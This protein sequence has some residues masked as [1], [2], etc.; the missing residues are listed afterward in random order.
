MEQTKKMLEVV[1]QAVKEFHIDQTA[2][3][4][5][6]ALSISD[7]HFTFD[8]DGQWE[9]LAKR[10]RRGKPR[11]TINQVAAAV[12][13][14][15]G[16]YRQNQI[17][18]KALPEQDQ[19]KAEADTYN[20][21]IRGILAGQNAEA[22]KDTAFKGITVGG[23]AAA[24]VLNQYTDANPFEQDVEIE[25]I[26]DAPE[27]VWFDAKAK[28]MTGK[29]GSHVFQIASITRASFSERW[30]WA[31]MATWSN[32]QITTY[33][34]KWGLGG[35]SSDIRIAD[36]YVK[37]P[38][39][40]NKSLLSDGT[41]MI[42]EEYLEVADELAAKEITLV[43]AKEVDTFKVMH[44]KMSGSEILEKPVELPTSRL[45]IIRC[46]G[47][48]E[49]RD[50]ALHYRGIVR[51]AKDPQRVY[52]YATSANI[53]AYAL[54][55]KQKVLATKKQI[56]GHEKTWRTLNTS[57][58]SVLTYTV[59]PDV[60]GGAPTPFHAVGGSPELVQ[61]AQQ[62]Q[63]D[64]QATIGRRAPA[65]GESAGDRSGPAILA[66]QRQ[67]D[68]V[69]FE[70]LDNLAIFWQQVAEVTMDM[71]P[72]VY[73]TER[74]VM[75]LG[76]DGETEVVTLNL[77]EKDEQ[78]GKE[79]RKHDT[80]RRYRIKST[81]GPAFETKRSE[82]VNVLTTL[83]QDPEMKPLVGDLFAK[84]LDFPMADELTSRIRKQQLK[85]GVV[86][87]NE[88]EQAAAQAAAQ[89]PEAQQQA[90]L[91]QQIQQMQLQSQVLQLQRM[92]LENANLE[93]NIANLQAAT[94]EKAGSAAKD[95]ADIQE[96]QVNVYAKQVDT[97]ISQIEAGLAVSPSQLETVQQSMQLL[98]ATQRDE[99]NRRIQEQLNKAQ[100][101]QPQV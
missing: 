67:D 26:Y 30:P 52:N 5:Q 32:S 60:P 14:T 89:T 40:V 9:D 84:N 15:I 13:E 17:E 59:D 90:Q 41:I 96:T 35:T 34:S 12:N 45:P 48:H 79:F 73:D 101:L 95:V 70:L 19:S 63:L 46:L 47:Y 42:T 87:P 65:Q 7:G 88:E 21:L 37:E 31:S 57:D 18:M 93:A 24:R 68:A 6:R 85:L 86:E 92:Q 56:A 4:A 44:Y 55:P 33:Q 100:Q 2:D 83:M 49:W 62:A 91:D 77:M 20:G 69:T 75:I 71:I 16:N 38:V 25:P 43:D 27:T 82:I 54:A 28:H 64:V 72:A 51:N 98:D 58:S 11:Y 50:N 1:E 22:A 3:E 39:T 76:D 8:E 74:Q 23:F 10:R 80:S 53:E 94:A 29:D 61:Q 78:T 66:M 99:F 81:V 36:Y 97:I